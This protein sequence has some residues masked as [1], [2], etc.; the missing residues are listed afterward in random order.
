MATLIAAATLLYARWAYATE[1]PKAKA[2][3]QFLTTVK[4]FEYQ[5]P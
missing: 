2:E 3:N 1:V 4:H 5:G